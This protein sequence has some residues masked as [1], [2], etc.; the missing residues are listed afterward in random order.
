MKY[1]RRS[2]VAEALRAYG[3]HLGPSQERIAPVWIKDSAY[4][5]YRENPAESHWMTY[6]ERWPR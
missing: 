2:A 1:V 3:A 5:D 6:L 4:G